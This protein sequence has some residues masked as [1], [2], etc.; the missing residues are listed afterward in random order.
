MHIPAVVIA[1]KEV[2]VFYLL[3]MLN[4]LVTDLGLYVVFDRPFVGGIGKRE[5][6]ENMLYW[7]RREGVFRPNFL[8]LSGAVSKFALAFHR[9]A[10]F[11]I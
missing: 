8:F 7:D 10:I 5:A 4:Y 6:A 11:D 9:E 1:I 2:L 3:H